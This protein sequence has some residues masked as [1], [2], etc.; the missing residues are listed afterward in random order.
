[1]PNASAL[2]SAM[3]AGV[4]TLMIVGM[5]AAAAV[6]AQRGFVK[7][8]DSLSSL[9]HAETHESRPAG[10]VKPSVLNPRTHYLKRW[11]LNAKEDGLD[12]TAKS[13]DKTTTKA[14]MTASHR[15]DRRAK[16][17]S[18]TASPDKRPPATGRTDERRR[19]PERPVQTNEP[20]C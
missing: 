6:P 2:A 13:T 8:P 11:L 17:G 5:G 9:A 16:T 10:P 14:T 19:A 3:K 7:P 1:M 18:R 12:G 20:R 4:M 15:T